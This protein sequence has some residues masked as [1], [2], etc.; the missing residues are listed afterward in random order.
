[1][2]EWLLGIKLTFGFL[3][4]PTALAV[5]VVGLGFGLL[6]YIVPLWLVTSAFISVGERVVSH[7]DEGFTRLE[8]A[9]EVRE[10]ASRRSHHAH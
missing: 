1:M 9:L 10:I 2:P 5:L 6:G 3:E 4:K 8:H 7:V